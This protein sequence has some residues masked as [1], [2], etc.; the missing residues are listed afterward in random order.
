LRARGVALRILVALTLVSGIGWTGAVGFLWANETRV[1]FRASW[2]RVLW[3][4]VGE[5][6]IELTSADGIQLDAV[7]RTASPPSRYWILY[8]P[9][10]A[11]SIHGRVQRDVEGLRQVG[12]NVFAFDYRGFGRNRGTPTET[13]VYDDALA[14]YQHLTTGRG[15]PPSHVI[16]AGRSLGSAVAVELSTRV[17]SAG[18]LLFS[19]IDSVPSTGERLYPWAPVRLLASYRFDSMAKAEHVRVPVVQVHAVNDW[20]IPIAAA[21]ALFDRFPGP[22][23]MLETAGGHN[24]AGFAGVVPLGD[25]MAQFWPRESV[26]DSE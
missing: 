15:V 26:R 2:S 24:R 19:A 8:C 25:A 10:A 16:L 4:V 14:A 13:G 9:S 3:P 12:Y 22:K 5:G 17:P 11:A 18:L 1:V 20:L 23:R 6:L 21:R 7:S